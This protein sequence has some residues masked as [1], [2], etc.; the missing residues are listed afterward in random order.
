MSAFIAPMPT[1]LVEA[2]VL[3]SEAARAML[4]VLSRALQG[5][6]PHPDQTMNHIG[7]ST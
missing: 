2:S 7:V 5:S 4:M 6:T 3:P 1:R